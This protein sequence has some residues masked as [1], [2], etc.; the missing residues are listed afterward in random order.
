L[1]TIRFLSA[2]KGF[3]MLII[4]NIDGCDCQFN[5]SDDGITYMPL[6]GNGEEKDLDYFLSW[7]ELKSIF[8]AERD[9]ND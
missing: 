7:K 5:C 8:I 4:R 6:I 2:R 1:D 3:K 9:L